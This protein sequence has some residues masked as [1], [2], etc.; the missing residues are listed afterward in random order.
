LLSFRNLLSIDFK[1]GYETKKNLSLHPTSENFKTYGGGRVR[2][3]KALNPKIRRA[4]QQRE[5]HLLVAIISHP[6]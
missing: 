6:L 2:F 4:G 5:G 3:R 1:Y